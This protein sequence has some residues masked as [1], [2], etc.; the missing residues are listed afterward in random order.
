MGP[1]EPPGAL[2]LIVPIRANLRE[3]VEPATAHAAV[4]VRDLPFHVDDLLFTAGNLDE[5]IRKAMY[6]HGTSPLTRGELRQLKDTL[7]DGVFRSV[8]GH[9]AYAAE[10]S[11]L[12][13]PLLVMAGRADH[14]APPDRVRPWVEHAGSQESTFEVLGQANAYHHDYGHLDMVVGTNA[15]DEVYP[16]IIGFLEEHGKEPSP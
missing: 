10:L 7:H 8:D 14:I 5:P 4:P 16:K 15:P 3:S 12:H 9:V 2:A 11:R 1:Q 13:A 6:R